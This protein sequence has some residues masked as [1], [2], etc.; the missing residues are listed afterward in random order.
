LR[1]AKGCCFG[2][3]VVAGRRI[4]HGVFEINALWMMG[5]LPPDHIHID[6]EAGAARV[7]PRRCVRIRWAVE[8]FFLTAKSSEQD[9]LR[10]RHAMEQPSGFQQDRNAG[11]VIISARRGGGAGR[12]ARQDHRA[13]AAWGHRFARP[14]ADD[15]RAFATPVF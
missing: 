9:R 6:D 5:I 4:A 7:P 8:A 3:G 2:W 1:H 12:V 10:E 13:T 15:P 14:Q 11:A